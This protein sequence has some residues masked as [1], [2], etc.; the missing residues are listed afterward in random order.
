MFGSA[1][2]AL[3]A[4]VRVARTIVFVTQSARVRQALGA[5]NLIA[6]DVVAV[7]CRVVVRLP[8]VSHNCI[9]T[10][11]VIAK[12]NIF[13]HIDTRVHTFGN[14]YITVCRECLCF[15]ATCVC[16]HVLIM[17]DF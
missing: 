10:E 9:V 16:L 6:V 4:S 5:L 3:A 1:Q 2:H 11:G 12:P 17:F 8:P 15:C 14:A 7:R 13:L